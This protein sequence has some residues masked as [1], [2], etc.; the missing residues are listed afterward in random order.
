MVWIEGTF[1]EISAGWGFAFFYVFEQLRRI[2]Y[3]V[4]IK[5]AETSLLVLR[6]RLF[7]GLLHCYYPMS[8]GCL[9]SM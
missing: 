3:V 2:D 8:G 9:K 4:F 1:I 5:W 6:L 7:E